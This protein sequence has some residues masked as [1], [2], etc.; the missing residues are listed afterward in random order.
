MLIAVFY[1]G[2]FY[3]SSILKAAKFPGDDFGLKFEYLA[4]PEEAALL[5]SNAHP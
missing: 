2:G 3:H 4:S 1:G 5:V